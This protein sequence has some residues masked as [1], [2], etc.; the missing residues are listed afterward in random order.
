MIF[1]NS[2]GNGLNDKLKPYCLYVFICQIS[3]I[4]IVVIT[5]I[6][7]LTFLH[8]EGHLWTALLSSSLGYVLPAPSLKI[9][10]S[11]GDTPSQN[12]QSH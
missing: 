6:L 8:P 4:F 12:G 11:N 2:N 10:K 7:N 3:I 9:K 1:G 5:S